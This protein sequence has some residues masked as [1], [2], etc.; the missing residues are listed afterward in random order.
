[1][2]GSLNLKTN[3]D[4]LSGRPMKMYESILFQYLNPKAWVASMTAV[5]VFFPNQENFIVGVLF[6]TLSAPLLEVIAV[7]T[8]AGF[9]ATIR[10]FISNNK[11]KKFIEILMA[12]LLILTS[13]FILI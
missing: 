13:A 1:M 11:I 6:L 9:G 7:T 3:E 4:K 10:V 12:I 5:T 2:F 8:W